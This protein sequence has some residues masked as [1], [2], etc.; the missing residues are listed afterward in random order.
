MFL[1]QNQWFYNYGLREVDSVEGVEN[2]NFLLTKPVAVNTA[3]ATAQQVKTCQIAPA[4][5][6]WVTFK[7]IYL[8]HLDA[9]YTAAVSYIHCNWFVP[10]TRHQRLYRLLYTSLAK[11]MVQCEFRTPHINGRNHLADL[12]ILET[13]TTTARRPPTIS[14][15]ISNR[16]HSPYRSQM[17]RFGRCM[18][19]MYFRARTCLLGFSWYASPF[20]AS[21][22]PPP[23]I[24]N[25]RFPAKRAKYSNII[26]TTVWI[27]TK[28]C[29]PM[30][31]T[32]HRS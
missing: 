13:Y 23:E 4:I 8:F 31:T 19:H 6:A 22:S 29:T 1:F 30:K 17:D 9:L 26:E 24:L 3:Y 5:F 32:V 14:S 28:F 18:R 15:Y 2:H 27:P 16:R 12:M 25:R 20:R 21:N 7:V 10:G 11:V